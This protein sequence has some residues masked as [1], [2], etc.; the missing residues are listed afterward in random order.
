MDRGYNNRT[1]HIDV[2]SRAITEKPVSGEMKRLFTGG[3]GFGMRLLWDAT[4]PQTK[5]NDPENE[6]VFAF[7]PICGITQYAGTGKTLV[8]T[9]SPATDIPIDSNVG[10]YFGPYFKF[11][12]F[13]ALELQGISDREVIIYFD[14]DKGVI[15]IFSAP[16][17]EINSHLLAEQL[18]EMYAKDEQEKKSFCTVSAGEGSDHAYMGCLNFSFYDRRRQLARLKQAGRGGIG[19]VFRKKKI[20]AMVIKYTGTTPN[21]N[22]VADIETIKAV[23]A[24]YHREMY[25]N[26]DA[27]C[28]M[29]HTGTPHLMEIMCDYDLL[30]TKNFQFG[31]D[32][33]QIGKVDSH[34]WREMFTQGIPDGC[35]YGCSMA[36]AKVIDNYML[37]TGPYKG[38]VVSV[39]GPEYETAGASTNMNIYDPHFM[40]EM[41]FYCDTYGVDT[42]SF[43]TTMAFVMECYEAGILNL[44][45]TGGYD[46]S[47]G[48]GEESME[49]LHQIARGEGFGNLVGKGIRWLKKYFVEHY[50]ADPQFLED[51]GMEGKGLE[52]SQYVSKESLAQQGGYFIANKGPQHDEAWLI[53]MDM[54][55]KQIPTFEDKANALYYFPLWRTWFGLQGLCKLPWNDVEPTNNAETDEPAKVPEHVENYRQLYNAVTGQNISADDI[56]S[57]SERVFNFQRIFAIRRGYGTREHDRCPYRGMG[58]VTETEYLSRAERYDKQLVEILGV[59]PEGKSTAEKMKLLRD[60]REGQYQK[61][62]DAVYAR[63]G[64]S[65]NAVPTVEHLKSIGMDLPELLEVVKANL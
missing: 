38:H 17:E 26:D 63:R 43:G 39:D 11:A 22:N 42:I 57:Q 7:G 51:I 23:G 52:C 37:R 53:F 35:W 59:N 55:N 58:P 29:R 21:N 15:K 3:K 45:I 49:M 10:G 44:E 61:L 9:I 1:L 36:C 31:G 30:P 18:I 2:G 32:A 33:E 50:G 25:E 4:R 6:I 24:K 65:R 8:V 56:I 5:W 48:R 13:D 28:D 46:L 14:G 54:V 47:F 20:K 16:D 41:N 12:G 60:Y 34:I 27:Q 64:W 62:L 19:S 40:A